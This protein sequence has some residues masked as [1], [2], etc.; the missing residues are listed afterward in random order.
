MEHGL[1]A[2]SRNKRF[3]HG[4]YPSTQEGCWKASNLK[5]SLSA[6]AGKGEEIRLGMERQVKMTA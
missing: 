4:V 3:P 2:G 6:C 5:N 1:R